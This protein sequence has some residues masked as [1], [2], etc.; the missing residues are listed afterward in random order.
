MLRLKCTKFDFRW[1]SAQG[2]LEFLRWGSLIYYSDPP[3]LLAVCKG[4]KEEAEVRKIRERGGQGTR[5]EGSLLSC[6]CPPLF[7]RAPEK[8][9]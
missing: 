5:Q 2:H 8:E 9:G 4:R 3:Y 1:G 7:A 6:P